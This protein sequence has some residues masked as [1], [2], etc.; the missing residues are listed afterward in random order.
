MSKKCISAIGL[1]SVFWAFQAAYPL[2]ESADINGIHIKELHQMGYTG[3]GVS[4][5]V[6][7][8]MHCRTTH[9]AFFDK[10][11]SG[12]PTGESHAHW[13]DP[14]GDTAMPYEPY[15]HDTSLAGIVASRG[16]R[17]YPQHRGMAPDA[18]IYSAKVSRRISET[19]PN[20]VTN[21]LWFQKTLDFFRSN[22]CRI[23][24][25]GIQ[26][27]TSYD[28]VYPFTLL[29]D[30]YA[31]TDDIFFAT[32]AGNDASSITLFGTAFNGLTTAGLITTE[33]DVYRRVGSASNSGPTEDGRKKPELS[34]PAQNL[35][36]PTAD[37]DTAWR[38]E[39]NTRGQTSWAAPHTAG[40]AA[41]LISYADTTPEPDDGRSVV[42][43]AVLVNAAFPNIQDKNGQ[44]TTGQHW[45][46]HR[47]YGRLDTTRAFSIL[48]RPK[49]PLGQ[50]L[51][52]PRGWTFQSI[53][54][55]QTHTYSFSTIPVGSRL[56]VTLTWKRRV[57]WADKPPRNNLIEP[58]ELTGFLANLNLYIDD[59]LGQTVF[60]DTDSL[61]NLKKADLLLGK[62]SSYRIRIVN[63]SFTESTEYA[64]A[65][66]I[67]APLDADF[68]FDAVVDKTDLELL[69]QH[70]LADPCRI[71]FDGCER[72]DLTGDSLINIQ[73]VRML[74]ALW[75]ASDPRYAFFP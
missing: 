57:R 52:E 22:Q 13:Y 48:S 68:N 38:T 45:H 19:D 51:S 32:A 29:Y 74:S 12:N 36:V 73:D 31:Y 30:Y 67:S 58:G 3:R 41:V 10:D 1:L 40:A 33:P 11:A 46:P 44:E 20:R 72:I 53:S 4:V 34:A 26:L 8:Q 49:V 25:T 66:E 7:S 9:E 2:A 39:G 27:E 64:I 42:L 69:L 35:W 16:G 47:G 28:Q 65:Y 71:V 63:Q 54:P 75:K 15:W 24:V 56:M 50:E 61:N 37:S 55:R 17:D 62:T 18:E 70:W 6:L 21:Y 14:T 23:V 59:D 60:S 43:K 5:G